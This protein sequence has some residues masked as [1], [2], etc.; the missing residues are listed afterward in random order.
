MYN[1]RICSWLSCR[2]TYVRTYMRML[3]DVC[4]CVYVWHLLTV[5]GQ[6]CTVVGDVY[7]VLIV[8]SSADCGHNKSFSISSVSERFTWLVF[9]YM[10]MYLL[11]HTYCMCMQ[12]MCVV[13]YHTHTC[14]HPH[15]HTHMLAHTH[16][17]THTHPHA[18][19]YTHPH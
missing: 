9:T 2:Y 12:H 18:S 11:P 4:V 3:T 16:P 5:V 8:C 13:L 7:L 10:H 6:F 19:T 1:L 15:T 14:T 17:H